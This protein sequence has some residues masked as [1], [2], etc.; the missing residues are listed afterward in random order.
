MVLES[1]S[2][3]GAVLLGGVTTALGILF[4]FHYLIT[5]NQQNTENLLGWQINLHR[6]T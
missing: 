1:K 3:F 4:F 2:I 5:S 6:M